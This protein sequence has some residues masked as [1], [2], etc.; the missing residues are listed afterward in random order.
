MS[1]YVYDDYDY[2]V[3]WTILAD[4]PVARLKIYDDG[5]HL[6]TV[7]PELFELLGNNS[8]SG[9]EPSITADEFARGLT[10]I[11]YRDLTRYTR[12][13]SGGVREDYQNC[14]YSPSLGQNS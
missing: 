10:L 12:E 5:W 3:E 14:S 9:T 7:M 4:H 6:L 1:R 2:E 13:H 11:G 8:K